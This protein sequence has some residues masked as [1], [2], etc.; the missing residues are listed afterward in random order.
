MLKQHY[1]PSSGAVQSLGDD[2]AA[3]V[4]SPRQFITDTIREALANWQPVMPAAA[5][6]ADP[7]EL[8]DVPA[9][10]ELLGVVKQT[11]HDYVKREVLFPH[12]MRAGGKLYFK[13]AE[14]LAALQ[15]SKQ[16]AGLS[17]AARRI[18]NKKA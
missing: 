12:R 10:A 15:G 2:F 14:L 8:L 7:T 1:N 5:P 17:R 4:A 9:A 18:T 3:F 16:A 11:I 6:V 13:R